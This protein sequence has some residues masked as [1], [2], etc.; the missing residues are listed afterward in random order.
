MYK[1][2]YETIKSY[3]NIV[4]ARHVGPDP[5]A[6]ASQMALKDSIKLTFPEKNVF[7]V[8]SGVAKFNFIGIPDKGIDYSQLNDIL[9]IVT[10]TPDKRRVDMDELTHYE[11]SI[12]IDHHPFMEKFCD[13][14]YIDN[15]R[16][17]ASEIVYDL[18]IGTPLK[19]NKSI[20]E[21]LFAG[22]VEDTNRFLFNNSTKET[23]ETISKMIENE[24]IDIVKVY[25]NIYKRSLAEVKF[26]GYMI[27]QMNMTEHGV[28][29]IKVTNSTLE[30][31]KVDSATP[32]NLINGFNNIEEAIIWLS[33]TED[34]K[35]KFIRVSVR[36]RGPIINKL[37]EQHNGGGHPLAS[38][39]K[40]KSFEEVD[41]LI[42]DLD[43]LCKEYLE[44]SDNK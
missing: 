41:N 38:G 20:S 6:M 13:I 40:L 43:N 29:V 25:Q 10:D 42:K 21:K 34:I 22:I 31:Y 17:S 32:G 18:I 1:D 8:G 9:L 4:I 3:N 5:D 30:E 28:G 16:S 33:A 23:F 7:T 15:N 14:E 27:D 39:T 37:L 44:S 24:N 12:K 36:S 11:K 35:N 26:Y 19:I 2:I